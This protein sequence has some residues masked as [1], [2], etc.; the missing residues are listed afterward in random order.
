MDRDPRQ[1]CEGIA[2]AIGLETKVK[3]FWYFPPTPFY[4]DLV[5]GAREA[6]AAE[7][8]A[9]IRTSLAAPGTTPST[10]RVSPRAL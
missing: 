8:Y 5:T 2:S 9:R 3:E 7:G 10:W 1:A 4:P 6:A